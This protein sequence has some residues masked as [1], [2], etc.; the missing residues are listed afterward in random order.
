MSLCSGCNI[1]YGGVCVCSLFI[2]VRSGFN[3]QSVCG[4]C[5]QGYERVRRHSEEELS[6]MRA[7]DMEEGSV[8][9][10]L[11]TSREQQKEEVS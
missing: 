6:L 4:V 10:D 7:N 3:M 5:Q 1:V 8:P 9:S 2:G 11:S